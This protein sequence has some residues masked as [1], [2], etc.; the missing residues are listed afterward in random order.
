MVHTQQ[1]SNTPCLIGIFNC[2]IIS[3]TDSKNLI[4]TLKWVCVCREIPVCTLHAVYV[5]CEKYQ[6]RNTVPLCFILSSLLSSSS[7]SVCV[8][9]C[10]HVIWLDYSVSENVFIFPESHFKLL[11]IANHRSFPVSSQLTRN[12]LLYSL[13]RVTSFDI[14]SLAIWYIVCF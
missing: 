5:H 12:L 1:Q 7:S 14:S 11:L 9:I 8:Q 10:I 4:N 3:S 6:V 13:K 2:E